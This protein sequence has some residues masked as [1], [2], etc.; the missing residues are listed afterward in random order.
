MFFFLKCVYFVGI[1]LAFFWQFQRV[2]TIYN[3]LIESLTFGK[4]I[5]YKCTNNHTACLD[6]TK[7][8]STILNVTINTEFCGDKQECFVDEN[9]KGYCLNKTEPSPIILY[10]GEA[11]SNDLDDRFCYFGPRLCDN[12]TYV[13]RGWDIGHPCQKSS[14]CNTGL[15]CYR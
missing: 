6:Q 7:D 10:P 11:C 4:C 1:T 8:S 5:K 14:D 15:Y 2:N 9:L 3:P 13:C 12:T